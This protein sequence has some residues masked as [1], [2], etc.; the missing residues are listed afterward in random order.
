M[1]RR[2]RCS[3]EAVDDIDD[4][5]FLGIYGGG[6]AKIQDPRSKIHYGKYYVDVWRT[7]R[8]YEKIMIRK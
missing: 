3:R 2:R 8:D 1:I 6:V 7:A 5:L 4:R